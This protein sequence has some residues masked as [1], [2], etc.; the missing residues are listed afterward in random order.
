MSTF[1]PP[2]FGQ[3]D[4]SVPNPT[5]GQAPYIPPVSP[6]QPYAATPPIPQPPQPYAPQVQQP[7]APQDPQT[8]APV[9]PAP[10][11]YAQPP[12]N[13]YAPQ[14]PYAGSIPQA[15]YYVPMPPK[16]NQMVFVVSILIV[17]GGAYNFFAGINTAA[18]G[19]LYGMS[20]G[21]YDFYVFF[22]FL[23][24]A[25]MIVMGIFGIRNAANPAKGSLLLNMGI[26]SL[27]IPVVSIIIA[28]TYG[29]AAF[30]GLLGF[31]LPILFIVGA[32]QLKKGV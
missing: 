2:P 13:P 3:P 10:Q 19:R 9:P 5:P 15:P 28:L 25:Y 31:I 20:S 27:V 1:N 8:Y 4:P 30:V 17:I 21:L 23:A 14:T 11:P 26:G 32:N 6:Q 24:A 29:L 16:R 12:Q 22:L 18:A 7:Y